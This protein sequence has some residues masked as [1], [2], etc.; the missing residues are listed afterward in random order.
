MIFIRLVW[1]RLRIVLFF[2]QSTSFLRLCLPQMV[3]FSVFYPTHHSLTPPP[4]PLF[5]HHSSLTS[6]GLRCWLKDGHLQWTDSWGRRNT[7]RVSTLDAC[8]MV[9]L[10]TFKKF[11]FFFLTLK[12]LIYWIININF[13]NEFIWFF[14]MFCFVVIDFAWVCVYMSLFVYLLFSVVNRFRFFTQLVFT[15]FKESINHF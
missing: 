7:C 9:S 1:Y 11:V 8:W 10:H 4:P 14:K 3:G 15:Y 5:S 2:L 13:Y 12:N 6:S